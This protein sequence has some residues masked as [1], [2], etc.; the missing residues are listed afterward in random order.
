MVN[1]ALQKMEGMDWNGTMEWNG[2]EWILVE[3]ALWSFWVVLHT[4]GR[5][6]VKQTTFFSVVLSGRAKNPPEA[7]NPRHSRKIFRR[8]IYP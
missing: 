2:V 7:E 6:W 5:F 1:D 8:H 3:D 4:F